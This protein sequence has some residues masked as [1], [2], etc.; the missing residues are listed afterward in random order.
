MYIPIKP[1]IIQRYKY[2]TIYIYIHYYCTFKKLGRSQAFGS[3]KHVQYTVV[4]N[5]Y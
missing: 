2:S 1:A 5:S 4:L 3:G